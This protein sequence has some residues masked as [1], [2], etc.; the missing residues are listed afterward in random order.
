MRGLIVLI[1]VLSLVSCASVRKRMAEQVG[2][3]EIVR[4]EHLAAQ[5]E[6][7][8]DAAT[9]EKVIELYVETSDS[10]VTPKRLKMERKETTVEKRHSHSQTAVETVADSVRAVVVRQEKIVEK[11]KNTRGRKWMILGL[12]TIL[13]LIIGYKLKNEKHN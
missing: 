1:V 4:N 3:V 12:M 8:A 7:I 5:M 6:S 11:R 10:G 2:Q 9:L 13:V